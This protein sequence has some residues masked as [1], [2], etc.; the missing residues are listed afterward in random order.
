MAF[1]L[2]GCVLTNSSAEL[3]SGPLGDEDAS[4]NLLSA[5]G[6]QKTM[7]REWNR[8]VENEK[9]GPGSHSRPCQP[10]DRPIRN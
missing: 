3:L 9:E 6:A 7:G 1:V 5:Y 2:S 10:W 4:N 8:K